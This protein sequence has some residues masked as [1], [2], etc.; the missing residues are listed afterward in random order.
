MVDVNTSYTQ[1]TDSN[2]CDDFSL[3]ETLLN[4]ITQ[5]LDSV[6]S[7]NKKLTNYKEKLDSQKE[8]CFTSYDKPSVTIN[9]YLNRIQKYSEAEDS[10]IIIGLMFLDRICEIS[11]MI[12]TPYNIHR[13]LFT[14]IFV[15]IKY[16]EDIVFSDSF[17]AKISGI[18]IKELKRL[19]SEFVKLIEFKLFIKKEEFQKYKI[20]I[21]RIEDDNTNFRKKVY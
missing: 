12:L 5:I 10:S 1:S 21:D 2:T 18:P 7:E 4:K 15:A 3:N 8:M 19:E 6:L 16:N 17:Y 11:K 9:E 14:S 13:L 20:Y